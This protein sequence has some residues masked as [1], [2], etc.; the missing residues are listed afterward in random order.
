MAAWSKVIAIEVVIPN[1][2][3]TCKVLTTVSGTW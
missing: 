3:K 1:L 2:D